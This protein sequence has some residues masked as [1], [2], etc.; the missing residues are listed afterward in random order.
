MGLERNNFSPNSAHPINPLVQDRRR[1]LLFSFNPSPLGPK[2][3]PT[4][5]DIN[6]A[7]TITGEL[8]EQKGAV[9]GGTA[10]GLGVLGGTIGG[11]MVLGGFIL[12]EKVFGAENEKPTSID[13][14]SVP[15]TSFSNDGSIPQL[16]GLPPDLKKPNFTNQANPPEISENNTN[17]NPQFVSEPETKKV[18]REEIFD[19]Y[20]ERQV[21]T[22]KNTV[23]MFPEEYKD[24]V[25]PVIDPKHPERVNIFF[26]ILFAPGSGERKIV[27]EKRVA[28]PSLTGGNRA[29]NLNIDDNDK[30]FLVKSTYVIKGLIP[31]DRLIGHGGGMISRGGQDEPDPNGI[32]NLQH[33]GFFTEMQDDKGNYALASFGSRGIKLKLTKDI[34]AITTITEEVKIGEITT[35]GS[36]LVRHPVPIQDGEEIGIIMEVGKDPVEITVGSLVTGEDGKTQGGPAEI[37]FKTNTTPDGKVIIPK[38]K[39]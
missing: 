31:G 6:R 38:P 7:R 32:I 18:N 8:K 15:G 10:V 9:S 35:T 29:I 39:Q 12:T 19:P 3:Y 30:Q 33:G 21:I 23:F 27:V 24:I 28:N 4:P 17:T 5:E 36:R 20:A 2:E 34:P 37:M 22:L 13:I 26:P 25:P 11:G 16:E 14:G 1:D